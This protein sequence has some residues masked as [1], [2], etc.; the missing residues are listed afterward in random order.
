MVAAGEK[1]MPPVET[2]FSKVSGVS[3]ENPDGVSRQEIIDQLCY[4]G[5]RLLLVR[6]P[7]NP[8][9]QDA[10]GVWIGFQIGYVRT[11][12]AE[13]LAAHIDAG[14]AVHASITGI[15]GGSEDKPTLGVNV[16]FRVYD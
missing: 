7:D 9:S 5:Q 13:G 12:L 2:I 10:I 16:E 6:E 1:L 4:E 3:Y 8:Y 11:E 15:T 14:G